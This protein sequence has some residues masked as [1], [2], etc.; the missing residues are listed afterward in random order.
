MFLVA[1]VDHEFPFLS[2][3]VLSKVNFLEDLSNKTF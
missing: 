3:E 2:F 1:M